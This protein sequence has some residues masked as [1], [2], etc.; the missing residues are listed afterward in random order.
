MQKRLSMRKHLQWPAILLAMLVA[1]APPAAAQNKGGDKNTQGEDKGGKGKG[2]AQ[3]AGKSDD[4]ANKHD[5]KADHRNDKAAKNNSNKR[6]N[7]RNNRAVRSDDLDDAV[8][9]FGMS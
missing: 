3:K 8:R 5:D 6:D 7:A 4:R 2:K 1:F 9:R